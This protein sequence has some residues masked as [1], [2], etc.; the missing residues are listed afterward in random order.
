M[1]SSSNF[2]DFSLFLLSSL[3]TGV[4]FMSISSLFQKLWQFTFIRINQK[5]E[6][7]ILP[8]TWR[9]EEVRNTKFGTDVSNEIYKMMQSARVAAFTVSNL[10]RE[11]QQV[12]LPPLLPIRVNGPHDFY[13]LLNYSTT[14]TF[15]VL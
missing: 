15:K 3:V 4:S 9:L 2:L 12:K 14:F 6:N 8:S 5:S 13:G 1:A 11:N 7:C 10:L